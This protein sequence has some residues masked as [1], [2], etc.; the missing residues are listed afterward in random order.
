MKYLLDEADMDRVKELARQ[1]LMGDCTCG[2][3][4]FTAACEVA[5]MVGIAHEI[6][7]DKEGL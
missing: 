4:V 1:V 7:E 3:R 2:S 5:A 6:K